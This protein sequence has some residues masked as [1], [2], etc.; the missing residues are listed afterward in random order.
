MVL[1]ISSYHPWLGMVLLIYGDWG[2]VRLYACKWQPVLP[3]SKRAECLPTKP[4]DEM[5]LPQQVSPEMCPLKERLQWRCEP[6]RIGDPFH[7]KKHHLFDREKTGEYKSLD[8]GEFAMFEESQLMYWNHQ[9]PN[10]WRICRPRKIC[11]WEFQW[12]PLVM[13][14]FARSYGHGNRWFMMIYLFEKCDFPFSSQQVPLCPSDFFDFWGELYHQIRSKKNHHYLVAHP[15]NRKW[16]ITPV[17]NGISRVNPLIT[18]VITHLR[19][20]GWATK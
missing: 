5:A 4:S 14:Q 18:G 17:I 15:T 20:V 10:H 2:M 11:Q 12:Y 3:T 1:L 19:A 7:P 6:S 8:L 9:D 13:Q 16:V